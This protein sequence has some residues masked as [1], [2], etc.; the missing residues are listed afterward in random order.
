M[1]G[2]TDSL[3]PRLHRWSIVMNAAL[4]G[5][6]PPIE[7]LEECEAVIGEQR[8]LFLAE[9][10]ARRKSPGSD[11]MSALMTAQDGGDQLSTE[12]MLGICHVALIAGH[13]TTA[14]T[15]ALG[16]AARAQHAAAREFSHGNRRRAAGAAMELSRNGPIS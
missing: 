10:E 16:T 5:V 14:N 1:R 4:G 7:T 3:Y 11:F 9:I 12:E 6:H 8:S 15:L 13:D 2:V